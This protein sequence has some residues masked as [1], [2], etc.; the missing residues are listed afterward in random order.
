MQRTLRLICI[1]LIC[2]LLTIGVWPFHAPKNQ[3]AWLL[4]DAGLYFGTHGSVVSRTQFPQSSKAD[5]DAS[6]EVWLRPKRQNASGTILAFYVGKGFPS[7]ALRQSLGDLEVLVSDFARRNRPRIYIDDVFLQNAP[8]FI[9][10][11]GRAHAMDVYVNGR[12]RKRVLGFMLRNYD[13]AGRLVL[14]NAPATGD[15]WSGVI[16]GLAIFRGQLAPTEVVAHYLDWRQHNGANLSRTK[17]ALAI[18]PF[19][20]GGGRVV[21]NQLRSSP[22]LV[23]P[24][25]FFVLRKPILELPWDEYYGGWSY[26]K[27]IAI[28][29][30]GFIPLG[31]FVTAYRC[32]ERSR[33]GAAL[34]AIATGLVLS[35]TIEVLQG[36]LPTRDSGTTDVITN[37][38]GSALGAILYLYGPALWQGIHW[39]NVFELNTV[40]VEQVDRAG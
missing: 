32:A 35:L 9:T 30:I 17:T 25:H 14:A 36:F 11:V 16:Q 8:V 26:W 23:I 22:E 40:P 13:V 18:Y 31:F 29:V 4:G 21:R 1:F 7:L 3:V 27:D 5:S 28:N 10:I 6:L 15:S 19:D 24:E 38:F 2:A 39:K 12:L 37:T 20:D 34:N 33:R